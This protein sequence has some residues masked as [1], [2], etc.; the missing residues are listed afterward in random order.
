MRKMALARAILAVGPLRSPIT[1][2]EE[3]LRL[4]GVGRSIAHRIELYLA[5]DHVS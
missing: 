5:G 4:K 3:A 1:S 2:A